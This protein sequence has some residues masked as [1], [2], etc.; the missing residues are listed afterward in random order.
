[1]GSGYLK[2][3]FMLLMVCGIPYS[4]VQDPWTICLSGTTSNLRGI[5]WNGTIYVAV[6]EQLCSIFDVRHCS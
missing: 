3:S 6:G 4:A 5:A 1:M 2:V